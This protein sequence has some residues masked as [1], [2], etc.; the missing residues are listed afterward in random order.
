M[1]KGK[2]TI[3]ELNKLRIDCMYG[4]KKHYEA[5]GRYAG[6]HTKMGIFIVILTAIMGTSVY[7][8][9]SKSE[10]LIT[11]IIVGIFTVSIA[12]L[13]ALQTYLNFEKRTLRHK[14][15]ADRYLWLMKKAQRLYS[16]YKDGSRTV[17]EVQKE[18][19]RMYQEVKDIQKDEPDTSQ[20]DY[21]KARDGVE[22][23]EEVYS[24]KDKQL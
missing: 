6:Y 22:N 8:S 19:D 5:R 13:T 12:V 2:N 21:Q 20:G 1:E 14:V 10:I 24:E 11:Q 15:T 3:E 23:D 17:D 4:K 18:L 7:C 9:L 16:Y